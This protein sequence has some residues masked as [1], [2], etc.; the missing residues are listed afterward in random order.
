MP[1]GIR[2]YLM[3]LAMARDASS[4]SI[5]SPPASCVGTQ[6]GGVVAGQRVVSVPGARFQPAL[7]FFPGEAELSL[8][9][10][11]ALGS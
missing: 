2:D 3:G 8:T 7:S 1:A 10:R 6:R 9:N 4:S 11:A 5:S